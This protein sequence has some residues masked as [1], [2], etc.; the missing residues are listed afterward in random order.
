[1]TKTQVGLGF[2]GILNS[3]P[4]IIGALLSANLLGA[5]LFMWL[6]HASW[7]DSFYWSWITSMSI[8]Y[9]DISPVTTGGRLVAILL[10]AFVLYVIT[11]LVV[12]KFVMSALEDSNAFTH[13]EQEQIK[14]K[15]DLI[16]HT[17]NDKV[18]S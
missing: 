12:G 6:E 2:K 3:L 15:L 8:G 1:M 4:A 5:L 13:D 10:G 18:S 9:G 7:N 16:L 17:L 11:P 14:E